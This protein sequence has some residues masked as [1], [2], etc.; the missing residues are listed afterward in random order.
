MAPPSRYDSIV[1]GTRGPL[2]PLK[3]GSGS[4]FFC[5]IIKQY[6]ARKEVENEE[7][8]RRLCRDETTATPLMRPQN[9]SVRPMRA[10]GPRRVTVGPSRAGVSPSRLIK[11]LSSDARGMNVVRDKTRRPLGVLLPTTPRTTRSEFR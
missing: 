3:I 5:H 11:T 1:R 6:S 2:S 7:T 10:H 9:Y 4:F 8:T